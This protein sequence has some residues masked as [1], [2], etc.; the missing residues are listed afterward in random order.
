MHRHLNLAGFVITGSATACG[1]P[2]QVGTVT[3]TATK[4]TEGE[5]LETRQKVDEDRKPQ[6]DAALV[7]VMK[8]R[9]EMDH[10]ALIAEVT[11]QLSA[12]FLP[13]P[14]VIKKRIESLIEREFLERDKDNWRKYKYVA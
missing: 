4:E 12:R 1:T 14:N 7:R 11:S 9:K 2:E 13:S 10:N 8:S 6:I 3:V 5:K